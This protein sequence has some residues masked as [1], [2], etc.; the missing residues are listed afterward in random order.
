VRRALAAPVNLVQIYDAKLE[1]RLS[2]CGDKETEDNY[3]VT[4]VD[5]HWIGLDPGYN[6]FFRIWLGSG[7]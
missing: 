1:A 2:A 7:L 3:Y 4:V 5:E 6:D